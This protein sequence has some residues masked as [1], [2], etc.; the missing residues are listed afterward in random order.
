MQR[1]AW[2]CCV[3]QE[4]VTLHYDPWWNPAAEMQAI[5]RAHRIGQDKKV[6]VY[7]FISENSIE[8]KIQQLQEKKSKLASDFIN[9]NDPFMDISKD[10][11]LELFI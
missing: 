1:S 4:L 3:N 6:F 11:V 8:E 9:S 10:D 2:R 7:R 5:S